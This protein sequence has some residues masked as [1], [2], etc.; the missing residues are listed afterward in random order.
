VIVPRITRVVNRGRVKR[1][2]TASKKRSSRKRARA[3]NPAH[4]LHLGFVNPK[5]SKPSVARTRRR[6]RNARRATS[7]VYRA[8]TRRTR[9]RISSN[10]PRRRR[11]MRNRRV[12][13]NPIRRVVV[14]SRRNSRRRRSRNPAFLHGQRP[15]QI[16]EGA[17]GVLA[18]VA[19]TKAVVGMLP[20]Q[21]VSSNTTAALS[22][23]AA[24][25][26]LGW[27]GGMLNPSFGLAVLYGGIAQAG[28]QLLNEYLPSVGSVV[29]LNGLH[30]H[31]GDFVTGRFP[32]P[33]NPVSDG[34]PQLPSA[35]MLMSRAYPSAYAVN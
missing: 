21:F 12:R 5:R 17:A 25:I 2:P 24:A 26:A 11:R 8:A 27:L 33:Q 32:I 10:P 1:R 31:L 16:V 22:S 29:G 28:S 18:G 20:A 30:A 7:R 15:M 34:N 23:I 9:R 19:G 35:G 13:R 6:K 4:L 14:T 3:G